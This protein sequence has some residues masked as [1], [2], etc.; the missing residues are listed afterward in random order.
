MRSSTE[1]AIAN[2]VPST[3]PLAILRVTEA[4]EFD[5]ISCFA[6]APQPL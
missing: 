6:I 3:S 1:I 2:A 4:V 5:I